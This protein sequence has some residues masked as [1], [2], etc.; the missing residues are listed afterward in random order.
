MKMRAQLKIQRI[1]FF[2]LRPHVDFASM[3][4]FITC[5]LNNAP[6]CVT[7]NTQSNKADI[8]PSCW[9]IVSLSPSIK[10]KKM[11]QCFRNSYKIKVLQWREKIKVDNQF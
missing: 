3:L 11:A 1:F 4:Y 6:T 7:C 2:E 9:P 5:Q 10:K 8:N